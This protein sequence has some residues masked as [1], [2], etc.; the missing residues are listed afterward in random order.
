[1]IDLKQVWRDQRLL[2]DIRSEVKRKKDQHWRAFLLLLPPD[3][4][5][6]MIEEVNSGTA[7]QWSPSLDGIA[8]N[9]GPEHEVTMK[10]V[11][12]GL[13]V[14]QVMESTMKY[15]PWNRSNVKPIEVRRGA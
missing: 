7:T 4:L 13:K 1:M 6:P 3:L 5:W 9:V 15:T 10:F 12:E 11:L 2:M 14:S 8:I